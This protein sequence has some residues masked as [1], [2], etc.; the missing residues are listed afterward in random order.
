M[1]KKGIMKGVKYAFRFIPD[2]TY[3]Q[4]YY[5]A[6]F[7]RPC[8]LKNPQ[9]YN[10]KLN[11]LKLYDRKPL[12]TQLVDKYEAKKY[13]AEQIGEEYVIPTLAVVR[14]FDE[15][16]FDVLPKQF[17]LKCT[18][19]SAGI[20]IVKDKNQLDKAKAR[21]LLEDAL[22][23]NF[24]YIGREWPYKDV[25]PRIIVEELLEEHT[26]GDLRDYK[27][28]C[29]NGEP[30]LMYVH[31]DRQTDSP[32]S[33]YYD[34][35]YHFLDIRHHYQNG[36]GVEKPVN[37]EKMKELSRVLSKGIPHLRVDFYEV[38]GKIYVGELTFF[39]CSGFRPFEPD[40]WNK[41][42][43]DWIELPPKH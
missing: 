12:Y 28:F 24:Y 27:F 31:Y 36:G 30:K 22:R 40:E 8:N 37:F 39:H 21:K 43:G 42:L 7:R 34:M 4:V 38:D 13:I 18:H 6:K 15:I 16:D 3:I 11:W 29:F 19:D 33:D 2:K 14:H 20:V 25:E 26:V 9:L 32:K 35:D 23:Y 41:I 1:D 17:V 10:E 5:F